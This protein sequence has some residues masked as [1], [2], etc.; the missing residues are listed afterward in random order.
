MRASFS[1]FLSLYREAA[2]KLKDGDRNAVFP[3]N[4]FPPRLPFVHPKLTPD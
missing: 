4:C 1:E 3:G 2:D